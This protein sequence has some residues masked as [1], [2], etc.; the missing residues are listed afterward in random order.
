MDNPDAIISRRISSSFLYLP[1]HFDR[2]FYIGSDSNRF[3]ITVVQS[4]NDNRKDA[5]SAVGRRRPE[6]GRRSRKS[7]RGCLRRRD[8]QNGGHENQNLRTP[9][10]HRP[11]RR[12]LRR[13][14]RR[15]SRRTGKLHLY[16][17]C[18]SPNRVR[19]CRLGQSHI[20]VD[21]LKSTRISTNF[22]LST[23]MV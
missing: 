10:G 7:H 21:T 11:I 5:R 18:R 23:V 4:S 3:V 13:C 2:C 12:H 16:G 8:H 17:E 6:N 14:R 22:F 20:A 19:R 9:L 15:G 1:F